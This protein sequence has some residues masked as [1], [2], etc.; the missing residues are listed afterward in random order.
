MTKPT[1]FRCSILLFLLFGCSL[2]ARAGDKEDVKA[3]MK[4]WKENLAVGTTENPDKILSLYAKD[5]VLWGTISSTRRDDPAAIRD[6]FVNA[7]KNLP[8]LTVTFQDPYIRV[9][10]NMAINTGSY[11][12]SYV[13]D[14]EIKTLP[15]RYSFSYV[16]RNGRWLIVDHH[17]SGMP[18]P[19]K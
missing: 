19:A 7:Y 14:A 1:V 12:F 11:T 13:K 3:A 18:K 2:P 10:G 15:A 5:A 8:K 9:Y 4:L 6:Y 17:S 16:K